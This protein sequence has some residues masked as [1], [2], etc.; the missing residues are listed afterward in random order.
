MPLERNPDR[1]GFGSITIR[2]TKQG[3][4]TDFLGFELY[5]TDDVHSVSAEVLI[6]KIEDSTLTFY[7][8]HFSKPSDSTYFFNCYAIDLAFNRSV[9]ASG[10][11]LS[12]TIDRSI[13]TPE[14]PVVVINHL[15]RFEEEGVTED[16]WESLDPGVSAAFKT[17]IF[18]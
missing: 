1:T 2:M 14:K 5:E 12:I 6:D 10:Q 9:L 11:Q 16:E 13:E 18:D 8:F 17:T 15:V 4:D 7:D 3:S